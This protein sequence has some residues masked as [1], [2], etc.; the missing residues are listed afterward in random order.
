MK[1]QDESFIERMLN[2][3]MEAYF[4]TL[5]E[6]IRHECSLISQL[7]STDP[8]ILKQS[9]ITY[10]ETKIMKNLALEKLHRLRLL[11]KY[12]ALQ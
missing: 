1:N 3:F 2:E 12:T 11:E 8:R 7:A 4:T 9:N 10:H 5:F 6:D